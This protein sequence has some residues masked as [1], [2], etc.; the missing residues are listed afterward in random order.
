[1]VTPLSRPLTSSSMLTWME[2]SPFFILR[3]RRPPPTP[4]TT[5]ASPTAARSGFGASIGGTGLSGGAH[6]TVRLHQDAGFP[7]LRPQRE[8]DRD[9]GEAKQR[10]DDGD[11]PVGLP[12]GVAEGR[13][14]APSV[15]QRASTATPNRS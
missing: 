15:A 13:A 14:H 11:A 2:K 6:Q 5:I 10:T 8:A 12:D 4:A 1:M 9:E 3:G 7:G